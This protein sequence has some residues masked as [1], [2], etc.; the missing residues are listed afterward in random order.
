MKSYLSSDCPEDI[1]LPSFLHLRTKYNGFS[2]Q[3]NGY[4]SCPNTGNWEEDK[5]VRC[6]QWVIFLRFN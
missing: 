6:E 2:P 3:S 5:F 1:P 4:L